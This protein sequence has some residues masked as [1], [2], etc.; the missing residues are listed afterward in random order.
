M[1][2]V[3]FAGWSG[4]GRIRH[5]TYLGL[6]EDKPAA[7]I[8]RP[9]ADPEAPRVPFRTRRIGG[10][11]KAAAP[12]R[13]AA[14][15]RAAKAEPED[16]PKRASAI[17]TARPPAKAGIEQI[18][19]IKLT[20]GEREL[21]PGITKRDLALYW[22]AV[23]PAALPEIGGR[24]LALVR[25]P[26]GI[27]GERFFQKHAKKG[28]P[29]EIRGGEA[30]GAPYLVLDGLP[31]LIACAQVS[32]IELHAWGSTERDP[33]RA[34]RLVFDLDPGDETQ[35]ADVVAA[36][37][38]VRERLKAVG[39][40]SFCRTTGGKGLHVVAPVVP[41]ADWDRTRAWCRAF[42]ERMAADAPEHYVSR[43]AKVER[44]GRIL[45]DWLRNGLGSTAVASF[46]PRARPGATVATRLTWAEVTP[47]LDPAAFT[48]RTVPERLK[49]LRGDPWQGF[50]ALDQ[51]VPAMDTARPIAKRKR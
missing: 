16:T 43:L 33:L 7:E 8:V 35:F 48:V 39:L 14:K 50:D 25:C 23:A 46:S 20:H 28:F 47:T 4:S 49:R 37:F 22:Q 34:D 5:A 11:V 24:L 6:R 17:V 19:G 26:E 27:D 13:T 40:A 15:P 9:L 21:W 41:D 1:A 44:R 36:A 31:G 32:A 10:V 2:E 12:A 29:P 45:V 18:A 42:A 38:D 3:Q 30:D 51:R